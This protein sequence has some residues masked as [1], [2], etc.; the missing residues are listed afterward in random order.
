MYPA[1]VNIQRIPSKDTE[2][3][4]FFD[5]CEK[6]HQLSSCKEPSCEIKML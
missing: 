1:P 6:V 5:I 2:I 3:C 4:S